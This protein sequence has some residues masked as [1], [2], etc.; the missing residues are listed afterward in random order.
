M[1]I[2]DGIICWEKTN[3]ICFYC[4]IKL[5]PGTFTL[6]H[7]IPRS[8]GG[9]NTT[10]NLVPCC[11]SCNSVKGTGDIDRLRFNLGRR[12]AGAPAFSKV[13]VDWL[14]SK[15]VVFPMETFVFFYES[16]GIVPPSAH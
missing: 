9:S 6:D 3:G 1:K 12:K 8:S 10:E 4:G 13:Q 16:A 5:D 11:K 2:A 15:G 7:F 14:T